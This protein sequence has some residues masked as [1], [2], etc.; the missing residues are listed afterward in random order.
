V[1]ENLARQPPQPSGICDAQILYADL[2]RHY[3]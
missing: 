3:Q 1:P 2:L